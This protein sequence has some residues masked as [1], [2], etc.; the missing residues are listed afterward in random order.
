M[1]MQTL[2]LQNI[3]GAQ[4]LNIKKPNNP[5]NKM[6]IFPK[7]HTNAQYTH[8]KCLTLLPI[9][10]IQ[11]KT[12]M[13]YGLTLVRVAIIRKST[14]NVLEKVWRKRNPPRLF[15]GTYSSYIV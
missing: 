12:T 3:Q 1:E 9:R 10:E 6:G 11:I 7:R 8:D 13:S 4:Q 15:E 2:I 14:N 5:S